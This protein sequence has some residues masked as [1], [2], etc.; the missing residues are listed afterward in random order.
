MPLP[1][2]KKNR[3][4]RIIEVSQGPLAKSTEDCRLMMKVLCSPKMHSEDPIVAPQP[5]SEVPLPFKGPKPKFGFYC[6]MSIV[7]ACDA[8][9]KGVEE[10]VA[11]LRKNGYECVELKIE[12]EQELFDGV[13]AFSNDATGNDFLS[14]WHDD[15]VHFTYWPTAFTFTGPKLIVHLTRL[16]LKYVMRQ[17]RSA[18]LMR[19][20][21]DLKDAV[22][23]NSLTDQQNRIRNNY[24]KLFEENQI[25]YFL[26]PTCPVPALKH[27][28]SFTGMSLFGYTAV[29]NWM[30]F[31]AGTVPVRKVL[32][33]EDNY[34]TKFKGDWISNDARR[35][36]KGSVGLPVGIQ[37]VALPFED[38]K[39][40]S[41]MQLIEDLVKFKV[42]F[43]DEK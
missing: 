36:T 8:N 32:P 2:G 22:S 21:A 6:E 43:Y 26:M 35:S 14:G 42:G 11:L 40:L 28:E 15:F 13:K 24:F 20:G 30:G 3:L 27:N 16:F 12:N 29:W 4:Q 23:I 18:S 33:G 37:V 38:E 19:R 9:R 31:P 34:P 7:P 5:W 17:F 1:H 41:G 39:V 10:T 25:D